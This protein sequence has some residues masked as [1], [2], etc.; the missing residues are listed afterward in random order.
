MWNQLVFI[1]V[2]LH[3]IYLQRVLLRF[4]SIDFITYVTILDTGRQKRLQ[5]PLVR[6]FIPLMDMSAILLLLKGTVLIRG[7]KP[8]ERS[9]S[10]FATHCNGNHLTF[11]PMFLYT[12]CMNL[13]AVRHL[14]ALA[15]V[16]VMASSLLYLALCF[17]L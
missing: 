15:A 1:S 14:L 12:H 7:R 17:G 11:C 10:N 2:K 4:G 8:E 16:R 9:R 3:W 6:Y 13:S 5:F